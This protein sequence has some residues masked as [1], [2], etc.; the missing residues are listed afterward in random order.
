MRDLVYYVATSIDGYIAD[1]DGDFSA[2]PHDPATLAA[3]FDRYPETCPAHARAA[4]GVDAEPRRFDTVLMGY[5]TYQPALAV[6]L[7]GG[8]YPHLRQ[9]VATHRP[10]PESPSLTA[11]SGDLADH[12]ARLKAEPG[13]DIWLCGGADLAAQLI[14]HIDEIQI[15]LNP[16]LL[17][18]GIPLLP[19]ADGPR[20]VR[21]ISTEE[22][23][24]AV[25]LLTYRAH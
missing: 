14:D 19:S 7:P 15:K 11:V 23:P 10:L 25:A 22:L 8:A 12:V 4:L 17:G 20:A 1:P 5:R 2:F 13:R 18:A 9:I 6:G 21:L 3:L 24:G 16:I